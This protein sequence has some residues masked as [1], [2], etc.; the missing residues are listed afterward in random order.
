MEPEYYKMFQIPLN[1][2]NQEFVSNPMR[3]IPCPNI[4]DVVIYNL[5]K[6]A[7]PCVKCGEF[8]KYIDYI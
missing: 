1:P 2:E 6:G 7:S 5:H 3:V 4:S 8:G